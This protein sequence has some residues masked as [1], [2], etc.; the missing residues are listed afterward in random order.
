MD[1]IKAYDLG[2]L[3]SSKRV[4][5]HQFNVNTRHLPPKKKILKTRSHKDAAELRC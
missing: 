2:L 1:V 3:W 4:L 5:S